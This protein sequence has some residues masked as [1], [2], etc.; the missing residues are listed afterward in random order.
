MA[1]NAQLRYRLY[2]YFKMPQVKEHLLIEII[3]YAP[4]AY[5]H[6]LHCEVAWR[7]IGVSNA[8]HDEQVKN[9]L[10]GDLLQEYQ[11]IS[12]WVA[13][14]FSRYCDRIAVKVIDAASIEGVIQ[15]IRYHVHRFPTVIIDHRDRFVGGALAQADAE[16]ARVLGSTQPAALPE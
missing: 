2:N 11:Q 12:D 5:Y 1:C 14:L 8:F 10:P 16:I 6:C 15:S 7:E 3:A 9:S 13:S 4:T